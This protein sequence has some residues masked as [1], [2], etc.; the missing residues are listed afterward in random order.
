LGFL[1]G[2][3]TG[4]G[5]T[6]EA[7]GAA[8]PLIVVVIDD[9]WA[10]SLPR[11]RAELASAGFRLLLAPPS[12]WPVDRSELEQ[13]ARQQGAV[14]GVSLLGSQPSPQVWVIDPASGS[15]IFDDVI[16]GFSDRDQRDAIA[17][18]VVETLRASFLRVEDKQHAPQAGPLSVSTPAT[19]P[20]EARSRPPR[21][22]LRVAGGAGFSAGGLGP[23]D[24]VGAALIWQAT[25]A[26]RLVV[27]GAFTPVAV[28]PSGPE[29]EASIGMAFAGVSGRYC[30]A[31]VA[32]L[33]PR[34]GAG[35]W[36]SVITMNGS[37][38]GGFPNRNVWFATAIPHIDGEIDFPLGRRLAV[39]LALSVGFSAPGAAVHFAGR[40][41]ATWGRPFA[42]GLV[43]VEYSI[44]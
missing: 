27:D 25:R 29:G 11:L 32:T 10:P 18:R 9:E 37:A 36:L 23:T 43:A 5:P 24:H 8:G 35:A 20:P 41:V 26:I 17:V 7:Q 6:S 4:L 1:I 42:M 13:I 40:P 39:G 2:V 21:F 15:T 12:M 34:L 30:F 19:I 38:A 3:L 33:R 28:H 16:A 14:G 44:D 22:A 31:N